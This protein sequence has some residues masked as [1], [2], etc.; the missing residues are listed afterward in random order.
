M[1]FWDIIKVDPQEKPDW[2]KGVASRDEDTKDPKPDRASHPDKKAQEEDKWH[3]KKRKKSGKA[4]SAP[5]GICMKHPDCKLRATQQ[6]IQC[7][8]AFCDFHY[9]DFNVRGNHP[10]MPYR[11]ANT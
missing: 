5:P 2:G 4:K 8:A 6:C 3:R 11:G 10:P 9:A 7:G 1:N